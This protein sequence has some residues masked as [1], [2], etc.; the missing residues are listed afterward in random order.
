[1]A[2]SVPPA[3]KPPGKPVGEDVLE[4]ALGITTTTRPAA[5]V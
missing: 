1:M 4:E 2:E 3:I 5:G